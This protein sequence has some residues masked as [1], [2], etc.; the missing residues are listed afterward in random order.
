VGESKSAR[1][2]IRIL[3]RAAIV[4]ILLCNFA[5]SPALGAG[6]QR[7]QV[8][9]HGLGSAGTRVGAEAA[10][11]VAEGYGRLPLSFEPNRGQW[12]GEVKFVARGDGYTVFLSPT[13][14]TLLLSSDALRLGDIKNMEGLA[15]KN[16][17]TSEAKHKAS[18]LRMKFTSADPQV[19]LT[20][21]AE[22]P[23]KTH[24]LI[25]N[26][27]NQWRTNVPNYTRVM[28]ERIFPGIDLVFYGRRRQLEFDLVVAPG[29]DP[30][31][32]QLDFED[33]FERNGRPAIEIDESGD[34]VLSTETGEIRL[35]KPRAYQRAAAGQEIIDARYARKGPHQVGFDLA[36]YDRTRPLLVDPVMSYSTYLGGS[37]LDYANGIAVDAAGNAYVVGYTNSADFPLLNPAQPALG[38]G[39]CG[40]GLD[41]YPCLDVFVTKLNAAGTGLIYSTYIGGS[42]EEYGIGIAVDSSTGSAYVTGY[43]DSTDFP[44][45]N[46]LQPSPAGGYDAFA[47]KLNPQGSALTYSTYLGGSGEDYAQGVALA[48]G[49]DVLLVGF[50]SST[51]MPTTAGAVQEAYGG[52][53]FDAFV[54]RLDSTGAALVYSTYLGGSGED[55]ANRVASDALG[56]AYVAGYTNSADFPTAGAFQ[57]TYAGGVCGREPSTF[58]CFDAFVTKLGTQGT[59][60]EYSTYLGGTGSDYGNAIAVDDNGNAFVAGMTTSTDFPVAPRAFQTAGG[61]ASVDAFVTKLSPS[62]ASTLYSTYLGALGAEAAL[63]IAVDGAGNAYVAGY[64]FGGGF[65]L[66]SPLQPASG[67]HFDAFLA[68]LNSAGAGLV[69]STYL[70]GSG[71]EKGNGVALDPSG[72]AYVTGGTFSTDLPVTTGAFQTA[73][74][75]GSFEGFVAKISDLGLPVVTP[76]EVSL[77]FPDQGVA[78]T[79]PA[80]AVTIANSGDADLVISSL[81]AAGDFSQTNDCGSA[82]APGVNCTL[83][84]TFSPTGM[85]PRTGSITVEHS[86]WGSPFVTN[87]IGNG[88]AASGLSILP[89]ALSFG[90]Q[91]LGT[92]SAPQTA[93][94]HNTGEALLS[95]SSIS[96]GDDFTVSDTCGQSLPVEGSCSITVAFIPTVPGT[97]VGAV[98]ISDNAP[99]SPHIISLAGTG[100]GPAA[101][102][103][104]T[105]LTFG[106]QLVGTASQPQAI[107]LT[108][109]GNLPLEVT[110]IAAAGDFMQTN[111]CGGSVAVEATCTLQVAFTP[112]AQ[113]ERTGVLTISHNGFGDP[114]T[115][116]LSGTGVAPIISLSPPELLF[117]EQAVGTT[118]SPRTVT[119]TNSGS[120]PLTILGIEAAG[121]FVQTNNCPGSVAAGVHCTITITFTPMV[122]GDHIG[123]VAITHNPTGESLNVALSGMGTDFALSA[124]PTTATI[125]AGG[126]TAYSLTVTPVAGFSR[127]VSLTCNGV[128]KAAACSVAPDEVVV[129][130]SDAATAT[131]TV[132][133]TARS[134]APPRGGGP[135]GFP[136]SP[137]DTHKLLWLS[138]LIFL[139]LA[140][141]RSPQRRARV[142]LGGALLSAVLWAACGGGGSASTPVPKQGTPAGTYTLMV[143]ATSEGI[144]RSTT[145]T[146]R[147]N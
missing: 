112:A 130:G 146:L 89:V 144:S 119:L 85:G 84:I 21:L 52:A 57:E 98:T 107:T 123:A 80:Q 49:G 58:P 93:T 106:E 16:F 53:A 126:T 39:T 34:L 142:G 67:G 140:C 28:Y 24:Y 102:L 135:G 74:A 4:G 91:L 121:D 77:S 38:G 8:R 99:G 145:V 117:G 32:V 59:A 136:P 55:Y 48:P 113:G 88:A 60:L 71:Q 62:G 143:T 69:F 3:G 15:L 147:V 41:T 18:I 27:P 11:S 76:R 23:T 97:I 5:E 72:N 26:N 133:T 51:D 37:G 63:D 13:D 17:L 122:T 120:A 2:L 54:S 14:A 125:S 36:T 61:G 78:T 96:A 25:G 92:T 45:A 82:L 139:T 111:N 29:A 1:E 110:A 138:T 50:T 40:S 129:N 30:E 20:G 44:L 31:I 9:S 19:R 42:G 75:G 73:Y 115:V 46:P 109:A 70:G 131:V 33:V 87:L 66:A 43:M 64:N 100:L 90:D 104:P 101:V 114:A 81:T 7:Q 137:P 6:E 124:S 94:L 108:N 132:T 35:H 86:A 68:K 95:I 56:N 116:N 118:S 128:P 22:L 47:V 134:L 10:P 65:P 141:W 103:S 83:A 105:F 127:Q 12:N 79:S